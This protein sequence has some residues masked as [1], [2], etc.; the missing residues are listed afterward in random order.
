VS[1]RAPHELN[2]PACSLGHH[3]RVFGGFRELVF[4]ADECISQDP[5]TAF[6]ESFCFNECSG[7]LWVISLRGGDLGGV[8]PG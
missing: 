3:D 6:E 5:L 7:S 8:R 2:E 1:C 4:A